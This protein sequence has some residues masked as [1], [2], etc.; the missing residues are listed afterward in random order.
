MLFGSE[1][2]KREVLLRRGNPHEDA[3]FPLWPA[4]TSA[5]LWSVGGG[6]LDEDIL[7]L[8][9]ADLRIRRRAERGVLQSRPNRQQSLLKNTRK[10]SL[11]RPNLVKGTGA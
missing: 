4:P 5:A 1:W 11:E 6:D 10:I 7:F 8:T 9:Y 2:T 3:G